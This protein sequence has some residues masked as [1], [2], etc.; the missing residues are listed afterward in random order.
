MKIK[1][2]LILIYMVA[3]L[4]AWTDL[5]A[6]TYRNDGAGAV[7]VTNAAGNLLMLYPG[8][9]LETYTYSDN[10]AL[11]KTSDEPYY[12]RVLATNSV[13]LSGTP[14]AVS[15]DLSTDWI[16]ITQITGSVTVYIQAVTNTPAELTDWTDDDPIIFIP[17]KGKFSQLMV[18]GSGNCRVQQYRSEK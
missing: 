11:T 15:V 10:P 2:T 7:P 1:T 12:N 13:T 4:S 17:A 9:T 16:I 8:Q 5:H 6:V 14:Q 3:M 18:T